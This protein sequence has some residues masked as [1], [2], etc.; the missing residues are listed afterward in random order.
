VESFASWATGLDRLS[1]FTDGDTNK[2]AA[3]KML[4][5]G[6]ACKRRG[7]IC[8]AHTSCAVELRLVMK[9]NQIAVLQKVPGVKHTTQ[10]LCLSRVNSALTSPQQVEAR[11][12]LEYGGTCVAIHDKISRDALSAGA[13]FN[14]GDFATGVEGATG[15]GVRLG[16][17]R[18]ATLCALRV[19]TLDSLRVGV[20]VMLRARGRVR[21]RDR[22]RG[23]FRVAAHVDQGDF[24]PLYNRLDICAGDRGMATARARASLPLQ[25][26][27]A[28]TSIV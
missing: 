12:A 1:T 5:G 9:S 19:K 21:V 7:F 2:Q 14:Q 18:G 22:A 4:P 25:V 11:S 17:W 10:L 24:A 6:N 16:L 26:S 8:N 27:L 20:M 28:S 3:W 23:R 15:V 13:N